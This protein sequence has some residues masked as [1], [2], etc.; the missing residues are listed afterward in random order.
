MY[1]VF[2][3]IEF[4]SVKIMNTNL[5]AQYRKLHKLATTNSKFE[6]KIIL[7]MHHHK[8][9]M[10]INFQQNQ[11]KTQVMTVH[12]SLFAKKIPIC[13]NLQ[14]PIIIFKNRLFQTCI[15][16]K[17]TCMSIFSKIGLVDRSK[18]VHTNLFAGCINLQLPIIILKNLIFLDMHHHET[19]MYINFQQNQGKTQVMTVHTSL[20]AKKSQVA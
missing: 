17:R 3:K 7:D 20:F 10:Y 19:Y 11:V 2:S 6:K 14:L 18:I 12:T 13:I 8:T 9:C 1:I 15:F 4:R 5:F 16:V